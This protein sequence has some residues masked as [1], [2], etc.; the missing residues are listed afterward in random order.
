MASSLSPDVDPGEI[1]LLVWRRPL[2]LFQPCV[3][4]VLHPP[5]F[6]VLLDFP[7]GFVGCPRPEGVVF[8]QH[9]VYVDAGRDLLHA[10]NRSWQ[11]LFD[12]FF[13]EFFFVALC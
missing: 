10:S 3:F 4:V 7:N 2:L 1:T 11:L 13:H 12:E 9:F 6:R 5:L 8:A